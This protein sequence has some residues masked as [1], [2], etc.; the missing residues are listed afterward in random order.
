M[1]TIDESQVFDEM[2]AKN[3]V[4][5][6][7]ENPK[8]VPHL[9]HFQ[10]TI[11]AF[12]LVLAKFKQEEKLKYLMGGIEDGKSK[13]VRVS[14]MNLLF[15]YSTAGDLQE[16]LKTWEEYTSLLQQ[17]NRLSTK[18]PNIVVRLY[19]QMAFWGVIDRGVIPN[20]R[21]STVEHLLRLEKL[22]ASMKVFTLLPS[23][24]I[25]RTLKQFLI[26]DA[27]GDD[28]VNEGISKLFSKEGM[29]GS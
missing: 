27:D 18:A 5:S 6:C 16:V 21:T 10:T 3:S 20:S 1:I 13:K 12:A 2:P 4:V 7:F 25:K 26:F 23:M 9:E 28:N 15:W 11:F 24:R 17:E 22:D 29:L 14:F 19:V 8:Q